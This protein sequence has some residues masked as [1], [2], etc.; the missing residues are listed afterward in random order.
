MQPVLEAVVAS[1]AELVFFPIFEPEG[2]FIVT[3]TK[4]VEG[5]DDIIKMS[6]D[7]LFVDTFVE[8]VGVESIGMYFILPAAPKGPGNDAFL[9]D[10]ETKYNEKPPSPFYSFA[11]DAA[12]ILFDA[13]ETTAVS[14]EDGT[15]HIGRQALREAVS[16]TS[17]YQGVSGSL[18]CDEFGDCG[19]AKFQVVQV[20]DPALSIEGLANNVVYT[21]TPEQ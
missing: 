2:N 18:S 11:Y 10:Y 13:I 5:F 16:V 1:G 12:N 19:P 7:G 8:D 21:Y 3:Q 6:A 15:L 4:E 9:K 17:N 14:E 20:D